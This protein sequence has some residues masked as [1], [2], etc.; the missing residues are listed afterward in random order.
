[1]PREDFQRAVEKAEQGIYPDRAP[2]GL[3]SD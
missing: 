3:G 2:Y 1:M